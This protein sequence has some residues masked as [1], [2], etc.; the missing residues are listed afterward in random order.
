[1]IDDESWWPWWWC[2]MMITDGWWPWCMMMMIM[3]VTQMITWWCLWSYDMSLYSMI[4][5]ISKFLGRLTEYHL[6]QLLFFLHQLQPSLDLA[7]ASNFFQPVALCNWCQ[8]GR[9]VHVRGSSPWGGACCQLSSMT[10]GRLLASLSLAWSVWVL[11]CHWC[12]LGLWLRS[13]CQLSLWLWSLIGVLSL[14]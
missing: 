2:M 12:Q 10:K 7:S 8:R 1:M 6:H 3:T 4:M 9:D 14:V 11:C 5:I 13:W